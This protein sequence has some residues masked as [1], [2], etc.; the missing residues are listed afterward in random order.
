MAE[1]NAPAVAELRHEPAPF[2]LPPLPY[3]L[4]DLQPH[5]GEETLRIH[6]GRH[7]A[8]YVENLNRLMA[9][10]AMPGSRL[11]EVLRAANRSGQ[12]ALFNN[13]AQAWNH[14][15]FWEGMTPTRSAPEGQLTQA[16]ASSFGS[17][18]QLRERFIAEGLGHFG[19][20]WVWIVA[21]NGGLEV[22]STHDAQ[23][24]IVDEGAVP[25]LTCDL[26]EH[27]YYIEHRQDRAG[28][29]AVWWDKLAN[30]RLAERQ[31]AAALGQEAAWSFPAPAE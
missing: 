7:H 20:G 18:E 13:A 6:H 15:F 16:I 9:G 10:F 28:W 8:K 19:S 2:V 17:L 23:T 12:P 3:G 22:L 4:Q 11:E 1:T 30:W 24:P 25:L 21:R 26:W 5:L 14:S 29:L 27:A 31:Y